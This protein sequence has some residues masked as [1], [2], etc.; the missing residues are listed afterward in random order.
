MAELLKLD[1][2]VRLCVCRASDYGDAQDRKRVILFGA[3]CDYRLPGFPKTTHGDLDDLKN[4]TVSELQKTAQDILREF[5][6][7]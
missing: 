2:Q 4:K 3:R 5:E 6:M 1:Y 7:V